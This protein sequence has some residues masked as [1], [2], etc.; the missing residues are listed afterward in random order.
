ME[1]LAMASGP[2]PTKKEDQWIWGLHVVANL[3]IQ[4]RLLL[5]I[6]EK[7]TVKALSDLFFSEAPHT[8]AGRRIFYR[9]RPLLAAV[10]K[11]FVKIAISNLKFYSVFRNSASIFGGVSVTFFNFDIKCSVSVLDSTLKHISAI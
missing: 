4:R 10:T 1:G 9:L 6:L 7:I 3:R 2:K 5:L 11:R 8:V